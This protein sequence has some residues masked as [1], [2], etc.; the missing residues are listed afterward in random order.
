MKGKEYDIG[1]LIAFLEFKGVYTVNKINITKKTKKGEIKYGYIN[2][3]FYADSKKIYPVETA[4]K[5]LGAGKV[6]TRGGLY[7]LELRRKEDLFRLLDF[8]LKWG[9][10]SFETEKFEK[11]K[12]RVLQWKARGRRKMSVQ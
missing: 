6:V 1:W 7:R 5:I 8:I 2:P 12:D 11:W 3:V 9:G 4:R 10:P